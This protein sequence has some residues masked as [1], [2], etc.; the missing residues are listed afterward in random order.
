MP[1]NLE[2]LIAAIEDDIE[3][4][5]KSVKA[6]SKT[7]TKSKQHNAIEVVNFSIA[8]LY[9][10]ALAFFEVFNLEYPPDL[11][12]FRRHHF[13]WSG[14]YNVYE[15]I[16]EDIAEAI[17]KHKDSTIN[18]L[19]KDVKTAFSTA[20]SYLEQYS[21]LKKDETKQAVLKK[22]YS[23]QSELYDVLSVISSR[24]KDERNAEWFKYA[25]KGC[26]NMIHKLHVSSLKEY[27]P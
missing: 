26:S 3:N 6:Y 9:S 11:E 15:G 17:R 16:K 23:N 22:F 4:V 18:G 7:L 20:M 21:R 27:S 5:A 2:S 8:K 14:I 19:I 12:K 25:S 13:D 1:K 10:S 24:I